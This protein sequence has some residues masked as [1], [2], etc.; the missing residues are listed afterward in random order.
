MQLTILTSLFRSELYP[1]QQ[2]L[3]KMPGRG[4]TTIMHNHTSVTL[5]EA[6]QINKFT[7]V[8]YKTME[9]AAREGVSSSIL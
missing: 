5:R 2:V 8:I 7:H 4:E 9:V 1:S 3:Q 6:K